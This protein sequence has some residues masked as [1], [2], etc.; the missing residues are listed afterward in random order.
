MS[1]AENASSDVDGY[2]ATLPRKRMGAAVLFTDPAGRALL[3]EPTYKDYWEIPGG[4]VEKDESP[5]A[6]AS[7]EIKEELGLSHPPGRLLVVDWVPPQPGR[8]EGL[9]VVFD[10]GILAADQ[11]A[12]IAVPPEELRGWAFCDEDQARVRLSPLVARRVT[13]AVHARRCGTVAYL[14]HGHPM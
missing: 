8:T 9:M 5:L 4:S 1:A 10:G 3:V 2:I 14:E 6:A 7:R 12:G 11:A 13:A